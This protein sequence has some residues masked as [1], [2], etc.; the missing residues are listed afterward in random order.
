MNTATLLMNGKVL[1]AGSNEYAEPADAEVY[2]PRRGTF[3]GIGNAAAPHEFSTAALLPD[4]TV[5]IAGSNCQ[6][7][8][9]SPAQSFMI[10]FRESSPAL[11]T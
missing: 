3:T 4:G 9:A 1:I 11:G 2:D 8:R 5:F 7:V 6:A 10:P